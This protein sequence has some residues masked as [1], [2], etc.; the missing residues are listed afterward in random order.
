M[1]PVSD[2]RAIIEDAVGPLLPKMLPLNEAVNLV[3]AEDVV[4]CID[5]PQFD[6]SAMDGYAFQLHDLEQYS[7]LAVAGEAAAGN[8]LHTARLSAD[9]LLCQFPTPAG[10]GVARDLVTEC[11]FYGK[12]YTWTA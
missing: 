2:A 5:V 10:Y 7:G 11:V 12:S 3:L 9:W 6:Q 1:T 4:A 8:E